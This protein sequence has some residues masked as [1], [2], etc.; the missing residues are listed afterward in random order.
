MEYSQVLLEA[1]SKEWMH[2]NEKEGR[3]YP[4]FFHICLGVYLLLFVMWWN[5]V[6]FKSKMA[7]YIGNSIHSIFNVST[8]SLHVSKYLCQHKEIV[9]IAF[10]KYRTFL[11]D[12][13]QKESKQQ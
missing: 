11:L 3:I 10:I 6:I 5:F 7:K 12:K 4:Y 2:E 9:K 1:K 13:N 8:F